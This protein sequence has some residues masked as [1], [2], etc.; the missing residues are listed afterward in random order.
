MALFSRGGVLRAQNFPPLDA[1]PEAYA[2]AARLA[3]PSADYW[4]DL[5][6]TALWASSVNTP[7]TPD[8]AAYLEKIST[9]VKTLATAGDLPRGAK[10]RGEYILTFMHKNFLTAYSERQT[11]LDEVLRT[12]RYNCVSSAALYLILCLSSGLDAG[13][14]MTKDH[15]FATIAVNGENVDVET[16]NVYGFDPGNRKEFH[17]GFGRAT[18]YAYVPVK[19]YRDRAAINPL[20]L[21]SLIL[22]NR[23]AD[24]EQASRFADAV[25]LGINREAL[26]SRN[27]RSQ[28]GGTEALFFEDP[29]KDMMMRLFNYGA[30][31][32]KNGKDDDALAW[33]AYAGG[34]FPSKGWQDFAGAALNN[35]EVK[36]LRANK[37]AEARAALEAGKSLISAEQYRGLD[38]MTLE[39]ELAGLL[40]GAKTPG[41]AEALLARING[42]WDRLPEKSRAEMRTAAILK[43]AELLGKAGNW[44]GALN[45]IDASAARY[46]ANGQFESARRVFRQNRISE[47][48]NGFAALYNKKDLE[49]AKAF[50]S[51]ALQ[52]FPGENRLRQDLNLVEQA[53]RNR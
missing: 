15:A 27:A 19:N 46:G 7:G 47:L 45:W 41:E 25:P 4:R 17:D 28:N 24:L 49:G 48:H 8:R 34:R 9:A 23:I 20:E 10:E 44:T 12:G 30:W 2:F 35:K 36:L 5:A 51:S 16:T 40:N 39:A 6:E 43:E 53:I 37:S 38:A 29:H 14:V 13:G 22:S 52:E 26:L 21:V 18:G 32:V 11:R 42:A 33:A 31:L 50:I 1:V 3:R